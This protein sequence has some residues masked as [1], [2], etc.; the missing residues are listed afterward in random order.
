MD[1][2]GV[3]GNI[4]SILMIFLLMAVAGV[5][6]AYIINIPGSSAISGYK[7]QYAMMNAE[8]VPGLSGEDKW[9]AD[10]IKIEFIAGNE[11]DLQYEEGV[12]AGTEGIKFMLF[13]PNG[14]CH[15]AMQSIT[16][17]GQKINPGAVYY[18]F[19]VSTNINGQYYIT[20]DYARIG[21]DSNW[22]G[23]WSYLKPFKESNWRVVIKDNRLGSI[24]ADEEVIVN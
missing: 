12:Y 5:V 16:M 24:I 10:A 8:V 21:D 13:D 7:P 19:T 15:E 2:S 22:G 20:N 11:L 6:S 3:S 4:G 23:G 1:D 17:K 14:N 9:N 18:Y